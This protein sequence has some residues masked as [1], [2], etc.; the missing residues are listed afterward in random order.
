MRYFLNVFILVLTIQLMSFNLF[1]GEIRRLPTI[2]RKDIFHWVTGLSQDAFNTAIEQQPDFQARQDFVVNKLKLQGCVPGTFERKT[3][4]ELRNMTD[5]IRPFDGEASLHLFAFDFVNDVAVRKSVDVGSLQ[6]MVAETLGHNDAKL[7]MIQL[8]S[9]GHCLEGGSKRLFMNTD[10]IIGQS[11][12]QGEEAA[13]GAMPATIWRM[14]GVSDDKSNL[15]AGLGLTITQTGDVDY[16]NTANKQILDNI[17]RDFSNQKKLDEYV[18]K[19]AV[20]IHKNAQVVTG[21]SC[22]ERSVWTQR[23]NSADTACFSCKA[24]T[25]NQHLVTCRAHNHDDANELIFDRSVVKVVNQVCCV[26]LDLRHG[27]KRGQSYYSSSKENDEKCANMILHSAYEGA[28][29][30]AVLCG[31]KNIYLTLV[32]CGAFGNK[33]EWVVQAIQKMIPFIQEKKLNV[34]ILYMYD[35]SGFKDSESSRAGLKENDK[36]FQALAALAS[37]VYCIDRN[38][39]IQEIS[40]ASIKNDSGFAV[41]WRKDVAG[42]DRDDGGSVQAPV[43][44]NVELDSQKN[45]ESVATFLNLSKAIARQGAPRR[46]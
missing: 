25:R 40:K 39:G 35:G 30:A 21:F 15:F 44:P 20:G 7:S 42:K 18:G 2:A 37:S 28:I 26:G 31:S 23:I 5:R 27:S 22:V 45:S 4:N 11:A 16:N 1:A 6:H 36:D 41:V 8:A 33:K 29:R 14:Y 12:V 38:S 19:M 3:I 32:G 46:R 13:I 34:S 43:L 9:R 10:N 17:A 24:A